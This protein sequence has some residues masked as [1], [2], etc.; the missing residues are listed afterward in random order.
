[1]HPKYGDKKVKQKEKH[2]NIFE[3]PNFEAVGIYLSVH[4]WKERNVSV[5]C[6][7]KVREALVLS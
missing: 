1:M 3:A 7:D 5:Y 4:I 2:E 6:P